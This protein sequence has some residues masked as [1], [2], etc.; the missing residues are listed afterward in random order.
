MTFAY[1]VPVTVNVGVLT[2]VFAWRLFVQV[3]FVTLIVEVF[4]ELFA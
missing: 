3:V 1:A 4:T 2:L